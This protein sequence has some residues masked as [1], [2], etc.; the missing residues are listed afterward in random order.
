MA[1]AKIFWLPEIEGGR[2]SPPPGPQYITVA[3]FA[4][5]K[6]NWPDEAWSLIIEFDELSEERPCMI[7]E[8]RFLVED[9]PSHLLYPGSKFELY[10]GRKLVAKGEVIS[11]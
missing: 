6:D 10:E 7:T 8:V 3:R 4:D 9:A 1:K 5:D 11:S 2:K